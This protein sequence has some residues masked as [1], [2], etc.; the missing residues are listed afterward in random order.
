VLTLSVLS[1]F[2]KFFHCCKEKKSFNK[3]RLVLPTIPSVCCRTTLQ[4]LQVTVWAYLEQNANE[5]VTS[6]AFWTHTQFW[7][8]QLA[9]LLIVVSLSGFVKYF[10]VNISFYLN[11]RFLHVW[12][13]IDQSIIDS[14]II[15]EW[16]LWRGRLRACLRAKGTSKFEQLLW[17]YSAM[18]KK[19]FSFCQ[20]WH[21]F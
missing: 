15:D 1:G 3:T 14:A 10:F 19:R 6:I 12:R 21:E 13:G 9:Y 20:M 5:D 7:C 17:Q 11:N 16:R 8:T 4:S 18:T 2:S